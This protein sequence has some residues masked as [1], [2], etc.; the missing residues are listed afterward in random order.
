M[1]CLVVYRAQKNSE[2][3]GGVMLSDKYSG[4]FLVLDKD[5]NAG[6][7]ERLI[8]A[9][10]QLKGV[11]GVAPHASNPDTLIVEK[12]VRDRLA[13]NIWHVLNSEG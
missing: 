3:R 9:V 1:S 5:M 2:K 13:K 12:R 10:K 6:E 11:L 7:L 4:L 8:S